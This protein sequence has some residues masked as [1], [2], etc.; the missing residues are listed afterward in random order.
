M[1]FQLV[2]AKDG[3]PT[4]SSRDAMYVLAHYR[5]ELQLLRF[6]DFE[7]TIIGR[8]GTDELWVSNADAL[9][10]YGSDAILPDW[11]LQESGL[12]VG[13]TVSYR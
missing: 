2:E 9:A 4:A 13:D 6:G 1:A 7:G 10:A 8:D 12:A 5:N 3:K 11:L